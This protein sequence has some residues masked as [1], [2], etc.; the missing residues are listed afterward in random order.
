MDPS[1][2]D[3]GIGWA[4][5]ASFESGEPEF[6]HE[7]SNEKKQVFTQVQDDWTFGNFDFKQD[8]ADVFI[9]AGKEG[10]QSYEI[11]NS[12][13]AASLLLDCFKYSEN[14]KLSTEKVVSVSEENNLETMTEISRYPSG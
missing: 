14:E 8:A 7:L 4:E 11:R 2:T 12:A 5:F 6:H 10:T 13:S 3:E 9:G 1:S